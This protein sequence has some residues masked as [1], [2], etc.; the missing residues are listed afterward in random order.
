MTKYLRY[1]DLKERRL[2]N[3]R[4]TLKNRIDKFGFPPGRLIGPNTRGWTEEEIAVYEANCQVAPKATPLRP[5]GR[6]RKTKAAVEV[7]A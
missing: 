3:N 7:T 4:A 2:V 5:G 1:A 6:A